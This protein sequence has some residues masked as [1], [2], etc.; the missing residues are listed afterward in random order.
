MDGGGVSVGGGRV[1]SLK[2]YGR[3]GGVK[4][5][6]GVGVLGVGFGERDF[7]MGIFDV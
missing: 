7:G 4:S 6:V 5:E 2:G 3:F 1:G